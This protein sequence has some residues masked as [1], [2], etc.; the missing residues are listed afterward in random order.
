MAIDTSKL[1][2][3]ND[4]SVGNLLGS[5]SKVYSNNNLLLLDRSLSPLV[6]FLTPFLKLKEAG[7]FDKLTWIDEAQNNELLRSFGGLILLIG[8]SSENLTYIKEL[9]SS[10]YKLNIIVK[11]LS[12]SFVFLINQL[13]KGLLS[14][15][16]V[17][18]NDFS[19]VVKV[20]PGIKLMKWESYPI[21]VDDILSVELPYGG[22]ESYFNQP[23]EQL[24][25]LS[26]AFIRVMKNSKSFSDKY[27]KIKNIYGK[28]NHSDLFIKLIN[29]EKIPEFLN[30]EL[31]DLEKQFYQEELRG[32]T[33]LVVLERNLD[34]SSVAYSQLSYQGLID[35]LFETTFDSTLIGDKKLNLD[36]DLYKD[37]K[38]LNF[39]S[40][41]PKLNKAAR[42]IQNEFR[43]KDKV[44]DLDEIRKLV[45]NLGNLT[46][47]Q[48]LIKKHTLISESI[49]NFIKFSNVDGS[50]SLN[51]QYECFL[52]FENEIFETD[53]RKHLSTLK[54]FFNEGFDAKIVVS[55]IVLI[56]IFDNGIKERD[57]DWITND[58]LENY[59]LKFVASL[60]KCIKLN[61]IR[62][63]A[64]GDFLSSFTGL[65]TNEII[66]LNEEAENLGITGGQDALKSNYTLID[67]FWNLHPTVE[68]DGVAGDLI[69]QYPAPSFTL[70][71]SSVPILCRLVESLYFRDFLKYKPVVNTTRRPTWEKLGVDLMFRGKSLDINVCD[72]LKQE[73][74]GVSHQPPQFV[75]EE[76]IVIVIIGGIT[77]SEISCFKYLQQRLQR[78]GQNKKIIV[79]SS[80]IVNNTKMYNLLYT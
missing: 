17:S 28:G 33:D 45:N 42:F 74:N 64:D 31:N 9:A 73:P 62:V 55:A 11:N 48:D 30:K 72:R 7:K 58:G 40:V 5:L 36:D 56:S 27:M 24:F 47:K 77:R 65:G 53:N 26:E 78:A 79:L 21:F 22:L 43:Q 25:Y 70:P 34:F 23:L 20:K 12:K 69:D 49:L 54:S 59:G 51:K 6:N 2:S 66:E 76:F 57:I 19:L 3:F 8:E 50:E 14:F 75:S 39:A 16:Y 61:L 67:K 18:S 37:L 35:D 80:G 63:V 29:N 46:T 10:D 71:S 1:E 13:L 38:D 41:G 15:E 32:N 52:E 4:T 68:D 44:N 60:E